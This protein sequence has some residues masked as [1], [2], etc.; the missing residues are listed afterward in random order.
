MTYLLYVR[1]GVSRSY[2]PDMD[3]TAS[4]LYTADMTYLLDMGYDV[5]ARYEK[6]CI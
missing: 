1:Y 4:T 3:M 6:R 2:T 5:S